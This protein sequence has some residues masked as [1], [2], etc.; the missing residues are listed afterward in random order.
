MTVQELNDQLFWLLDQLAA[1]H[2]AY[3]SDGVER[4]YKAPDG[5]TDISQGDY[6]WRL[7][8]RIDATRKALD[9][10]YEIARGPVLTKEISTATHFS[11]G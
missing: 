8:A 3:S 5:V 6:I 4:S 2:E 7:Q 1:V 11:P 10:R 9:C